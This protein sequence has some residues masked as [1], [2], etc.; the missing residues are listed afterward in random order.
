[1]SYNSWNCP[2]EMGFFFF[3]YLPKLHILWL[4]FHIILYIHFNNFD[5][6]SILFNRFYHFLVH[7]ESYI[8]VFMLHVQCFNRNYIKAP[9]C[10][11][12][13]ER[14]F[15]TT[16]SLREE[17]MQFISENWMKLNEYWSLHCMLLVS[18]TSSN[19]I[20]ISWGTYHSSDKSG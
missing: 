9:D 12:A 10:D 16:D 20:L 2:K 6:V 7:S 4:Y 14:V 5:I 3:Y 1:M 8:T 18:H 19:R 15:R 13:L 17:P 11:N